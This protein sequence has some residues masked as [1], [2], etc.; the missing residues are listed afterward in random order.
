MKTKTDH[1]PFPV[2]VNIPYVFASS[3]VV[4]MIAVVSIFDFHDGMPNDPFWKEKNIRV[5]S[6]KRKR[7]VFLQMVLCFKIEIH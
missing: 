4:P 6:V 3:L 1:L 5:L 2:S 7:D